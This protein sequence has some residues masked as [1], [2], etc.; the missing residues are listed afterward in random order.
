MIDMI[1][2]LVLSSVSA[3]T[4]DDSC[5]ESKA[6]RILSFSRKPDVPEDMFHMGCEQLLIYQLAHLTRPDAKHFLEAG[7]NLGYIGSRIFSLWSPGSGLDPVSLHARLERDWH[8]SNSASTC[9]D[10]M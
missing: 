6:A 9:H 1:F 10:G 2:F 7:T 8:G 3:R 4:N 5:P